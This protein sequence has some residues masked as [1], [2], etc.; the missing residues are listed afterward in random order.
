MSEFNKIYSNNQLLF[1]KLQEGVGKLADNVATTLGPA[2]RNVILQQKGRK[3]FITKD[4]VTVA[5]FVD[6]KDPVENLG[7]QIVKEVALKTNEQAGDGTTTSIVLARRLLSNSG[8][9]LREQHRPI[10]LKRGMD[11]A[12]EDV[13]EY[14]VEN[15]IPVKSLDDIKNI[16]KISANNDESIGELIRMAID[17]AGKNGA[18]SI[19][20]AR[21]AETELELRE[22][23]RFDAGWAS[24]EFTND[25]KGR[26]TKFDDCLVF[27]SEKPLE[28]IEEIMPMLEKAS[29][30]VKPLFIVAEDYSKE[31]LAGFIMNAARG[32]MKVC[33]VKA[34]LYGQERRNL[35]SDLALSVGAKLFGRKNSLDLKNFKLE[36][37]GRADNV[38]VTKLSTT[39]VGGQGDEEDL[40]S[41][42]EELQEDIKE[43]QDFS[44]CEQIQERITRLSSGVAII[45]VGASS[46]IEMIEKKHRIEDA[47][48]AVSAAQ[49]SGIHAGGGVAL[50]RAQ[51]A[52]KKKVRGNTEAE[53]VGYLLVLNSLSAPLE[54]MCT[55][56]GLNG[57]TVEKVS[58]MKGNFG[59]DIKS[60][61]K[62][63]MI[64]IG[65]ID[66]VAVTCAA[67]INAVSVVST[68]VTTN[69]AI[70]ET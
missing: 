65:I 13:I 30:E 8:K 33:V 5:K 60:N 23:F 61:K 46:E 39:I 68:V 48:E 16:A 2:G 57:Q 26:M 58:R 49:K 3:P 62:V 45:N 56:A 19:A 20:E 24:Q 42:I 11:Y 47:L 38:E 37:F 63:D 67:L 21:Q 52:M 32:T 7:A 27:V 1:E 50:M 69:Y 44:V 36:N 51:R 64:K 70:L 66:P 28:S 14:L 6:L 12:L 18:I 25:E 22:G 9:A 29:R 10:D 34:P 59:Y 15:S 55:N 41:R 17:Q 35:L 31:V 40:D 4:G 54:Q 53:R 43:E